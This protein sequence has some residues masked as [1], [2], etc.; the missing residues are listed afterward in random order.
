M[1]DVSFS[2]VRVHN[3]VQFCMVKNPDIKRKLESLFQQNRIS[4]Y[5]KWE[6][7][8]FLKRL[9]HA[10]D[11]NVCT[12]CINEM[13]KERALEVVESHPELMGGIQLVSGRV[14]KT[15]FY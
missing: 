10:D 3:E 12:F 8:T 9:F 4:Y 13:Q 11:V 14:K 7:D 1:G 2:H 5:E 15:F 6:N